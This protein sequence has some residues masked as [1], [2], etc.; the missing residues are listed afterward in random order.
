LDVGIP[1]DFFFNYKNIGDSKFSTPHNLVFIEI[2]IYH[3]A[4]FPLTLQPDNNK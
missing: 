4:I 2:R 3:H 1:A